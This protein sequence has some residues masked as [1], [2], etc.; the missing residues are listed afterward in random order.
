[1]KHVLIAV[2]ENEEQAVA[3]ARTVRDVFDPDAVRAHLFH[4]FVENAEGASLA[5][6]GPRGGDCRRP[7]G[8]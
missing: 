5:R 1:M 6:Y 4:D 2:D 7:D 3:H 8:E